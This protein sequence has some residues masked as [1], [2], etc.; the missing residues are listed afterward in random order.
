MV[1][2]GQPAT[3]LFGHVPDWVATT[4][5]AL[6]RSVMFCSVA[7]VSAMAPICALLACRGGV[8]VSL[9]APS[10]TSPEKPDTPVLS[11][12]WEVIVDQLSCAWL[13]P[14]P[15]KKCSR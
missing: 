8:L 9:K 12:Y 6:S 11:A 2:V 7:N 5:C 3:K 1:L 4:I 10:N 13:L 15:E 14:S